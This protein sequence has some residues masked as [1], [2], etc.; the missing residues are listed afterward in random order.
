MAVILSI[1]FIKNGFQK[2]LLNSIISNKFI[3]KSRLTLVIWRVCRFAYT[4]LVF[5][6]KLYSETILQTQDT[7]AKYMQCGGLTKA[8]TSGY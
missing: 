1:T 3:R 2:L 8:I 5:Y 4:S 6:F 7:Q